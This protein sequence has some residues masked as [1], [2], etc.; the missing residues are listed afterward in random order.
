MDAA[1]LA[2]NEQLVLLTYHKRLTMRH[3]IEFHPRRL[4]FTTRAEPRSVQE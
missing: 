1:P 4:R 3:S 2:L